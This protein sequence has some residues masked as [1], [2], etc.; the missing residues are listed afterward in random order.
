MERSSLRGRIYASMFGALTAVGAY[1]VIPVPPVPVT[2]QTFFL[3]L[4][5]CLLGGP[6]GAWSQ[7][8]YVLIGAIG[9]P[10]F[11]AGKGGLGVLL[12]P[13]GGYLIG[14]I[15]GAYVTGRLARAG[16]PAGAFRLLLA[17][18][19]GT[20][21]LYA[22]GV[23]QLMVVAK[24]SPAKALAVGIVPFLPGDAAKMAAAV[25]IVR[26]LR[27]RMPFRGAPQ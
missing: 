13:T 25:F 24:L 16:K 20:A 19:A 8:V 1:I 12:G 4:A 11:A 18:V 9:L 6:L 27:N 10:V 5:A 23:A 26:M 21:C 17:M 7:I 3:Y 14:F 2:M 22:L 15:V